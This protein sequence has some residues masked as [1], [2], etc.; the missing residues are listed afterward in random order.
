MHSCAGVSYCG[1]FM[2]MLLETQRFVGFLLPPSPPPP[3]AILYKR[4]ILV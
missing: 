3:P 1:T 2:L 4:K